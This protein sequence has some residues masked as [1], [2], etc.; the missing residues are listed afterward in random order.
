MSNA[1]N[2]REDFSLVNNLV[3]QYPKKLEEI[4]SLFMPQAEKHHV[5]LIDHRV[6]ELMNPEIADPTDIIAN[7]TSLNLC[8]GIEG[9]IK[10]LLHQY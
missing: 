5:L 3:A 9:M 10:K 4:K 7:K 6:I 1:S 8:E 2:T